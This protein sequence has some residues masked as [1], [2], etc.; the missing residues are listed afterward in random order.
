[1][2]MIHVHCIYTCNTGTMYMYTNLYTCTYSNYSLSYSV[3]VSTVLYSKK[4]I[5]IQGLSKA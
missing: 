2:N 3:R 5:S 1:M 4:L